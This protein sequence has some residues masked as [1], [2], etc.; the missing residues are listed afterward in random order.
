[1]QVCHILRAN[2]SRTAFLN[3]RSFERLDTMPATVFQYYYQLQV[4]NLHFN[5]PEAD[6]ICWI[7][8]NSSFRRYKRKEWESLSLSKKR[9]YHALYFHFTGLSYRT[10]GHEELA[11]KLE[12]PIPAASDYLLFRNGF[13]A[14]FDLLWEEQQKHDVMKRTPKLMLRS[15]SSGLVKKTRFL[16]AKAGKTDSDLTRRFH[17]MCRECRRI[18]REEVDNIQRTEIAEKL[19]EERRFFEKLMSK[20]IE[21]LDSLQG[22]LVKNLRAL[23]TPSCQEFD[24]EKRS[25]EQT[26]GSL[27]FLMTRSSKD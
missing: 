23:N 4:K 2:V 27:A 26:T 8:R 15:G 24:F 7:N 3:R 16:A 25:F 19:R 11:R 17:D 20:E 6:L 12:Y 21:I 5:V 13:K 18:W 14:K 10:I 9:I 22:S 1:M